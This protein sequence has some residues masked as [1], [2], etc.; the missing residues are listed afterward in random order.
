MGQHHLM[1]TSVAG[2][3]AMLL[4]QAAYLMALVVLTPISRHGILHQLDPFHQCSVTQHP[5]TKTLAI[6][7][8]QVKQA[9]A[10]CLMAQ[11]PLTKTLVVGI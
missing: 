10:I 4:I 7:T 8:F 9:L 6:G 11:H 3:L 2:M 1:V 5:L